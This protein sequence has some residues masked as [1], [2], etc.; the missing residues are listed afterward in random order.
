MCTVLFF[1]FFSNF[2]LHFFIL[3]WAPQI[4]WPILPV[5]FQLLHSLFALWLFL[6]HVR[7]APLARPIHILLPLPGML[8]PQMST[9]GFLTSITLFLLIKSFHESSPWPPLFKVQSLL[10]RQHL[11][12]FFS[13]SYGTF[14]LLTYYVFYLMCLFVFLPH[15]C[16][17]RKCMNDCPGIKS[18]G[19]RV[20]YS[21]FSYRIPHFNQ[22][23]HFKPICLLS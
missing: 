7:N 22:M 8:S 10:A 12:L 23:T 6:K 5:P 4:M 17:L 2:V 21:F 9:A 16:V 1:S 13:D 11:I 18:W 3:H 14:H 15:K 19:Y 20:I